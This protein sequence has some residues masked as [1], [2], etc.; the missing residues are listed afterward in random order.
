MPEAIVQLTADYVTA[1]TSALAL[2]IGPPTPGNWLILVV[3]EAPLP[4]GYSVPDEWSSYTS[5]VYIRPTGTFADCAVTVFFYVAQ[6]GD[7]GVV[8]L[9]ATA[10]ARSIAGVL[11]EVNGV[12]SVY[13]YSL[14][15]VPAAAGP[16]ATVDDLQSMLA[17]SSE[18]FAVFIAGMLGPT[19]S[20]LPGLSI[21]NNFDFVTAPI[22]SGTGSGE[23]ALAV[24]TP[25]AGPYD[26]TVD[27]D[28]GLTTMSWT[29][30]ADHVGAFTI[31]IS[32]F[33]PPTYTGGWVYSGPAF[34]GTTAVYDAGPYAGPWPP[35]PPDPSLLPVDALE[36]DYFVGLPPPGDDPDRIFDGTYPAQVYDTFTYWDSYPATL[37]DPTT[38]GGV[39]Y[40]VGGASDDGT[41]DSGAHLYVVWYSPSY[42]VADQ[43]SVTGPSLVPEGWVL[44]GG[45]LATAGR[46]DSS[47]SSGQPSAVLADVVGA[48]SSWITKARIPS[49]S[50]VIDAV[51]GQTVSSI[52]AVVDMGDNEPIALALMFSA[53]CEVVMEE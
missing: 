19:G 4:S 13:Q 15:D 44:P 1:A 34:G 50:V 11:L 5:G 23:V 31:L 32:D 51:A 37:G 43:P 26:A 42:P 14:P 38:S 36:I 29:N 9:P 22:Q 49:G 17:N 3:A 12:P 27:T 20:I 46:T 33:V 2:E 39:H 10:S 21:D 24:A 47:I 7:G 30:S 8:T 45:S 41:L 25:L 52:L 18:D 6:S 53:Q 16:A 48:T 35:T 40:A 28:T